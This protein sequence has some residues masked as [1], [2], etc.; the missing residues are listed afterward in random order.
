MIQINKLHQLLR[1]IILTWTNKTECVQYLAEA[2]ELWGKQARNSE[3]KGS[4]IMLRGKRNYV[5]IGKQAL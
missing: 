5:Y 4:D 3:I 2:R 1:Q